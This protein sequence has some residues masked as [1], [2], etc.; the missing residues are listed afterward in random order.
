VP[1]KQVTSISKILM[2]GNNLLSLIEDLRNPKSNVHLKTNHKIKV[3]M[4]EMANFKEEIEESE[5]TRTRRRHS[6]KRGILK[7]MAQMQI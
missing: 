3:A 7:G 2:Y 4:G 1:I 6:C 5:Q